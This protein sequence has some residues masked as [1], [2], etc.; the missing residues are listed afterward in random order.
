LNATDKVLETK[1]KYKH[2]YG[3][4][5]FLLPYLSIEIVF[6]RAA[7]LKSFVCGIHSTNIG[8]PGEVFPK[9]KKI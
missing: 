6:K 3:F 1:V 9:L 8:R 2:R 4:N 5:P 7:Q